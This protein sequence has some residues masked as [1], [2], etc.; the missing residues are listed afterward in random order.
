MP[1][2]FA[3]LESFFDVRLAALRPCSGRLNPF[4]PLARPTAIPPTRPASPTP[5]AIAGALSCWA[6]DAT[7]LPA[8]FAL[9]TAVS[10]LFDDLDALRVEDAVGRGLPR[11]RL[12]FEPPPDLLFVC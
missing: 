6:V 10:L 7:A 5:A 8:S 4:L 2:F 1:T 9:V 11:D 12:P 3:A